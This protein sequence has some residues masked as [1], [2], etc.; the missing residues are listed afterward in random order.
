LYS[1]ALLAGTVVVDSV[2]GRIPTFWHDDA[3]RRVKFNGVGEWLERLAE[4]ME[5]GSYKFS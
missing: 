5:N 1:P 3:L 2:S 4:A